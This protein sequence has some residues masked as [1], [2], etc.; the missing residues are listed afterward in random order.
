MKTKLL[1]LCTVLSSGLF[2]Y[3]Q[4]T[5]LWR[6]ENPKNSHVSYLNGTNHLLTDHYLE[7]F[8]IISQKMS[9]AETVVFELDQDDLKKQKKAVESLPENEE[10]KKLLTQEQREKVVKYLGRNALKRTPMGLVAM[11]SIYN[12]VSN[13]PS[14]KGE[15]IEIAL[16][17]IA[18]S[19]SKKI[20]YLETGDQQ[21]ETVNQA[22]SGGIT[23]FLAKKSLNQ[24]V[25]ELG[26]TIVKDDPANSIQKYY[27]QQFNYFLNRSVM[28][29]YH[30]TLLKDRNENWI[31]QI[32][33]IIDEQNAFISV[34]SMHL[35]YNSGLI[36]QLMKLG[37][38]LT[39]VDMKTGRDLP[40]NR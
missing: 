35:Q 28:T 31:K 37:Y 10:L 19:Q 2:S 3:A 39:P 4:N 5:F 21:M 11:I 1:L 9:E 25:N 12:T 36:S 38:K 6:I 32:P 34:G 7:S 13:H 22:Q 8:P 33:G 17:K 18:V 24:M 26:N 30:K 27:D 20:I 40:F 23:A 16:K 15:N 29:K 14:S